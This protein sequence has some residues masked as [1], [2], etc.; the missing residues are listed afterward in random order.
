MTATATPPRREESQPVEPA[1]HQ[2]SRAGLLAGAVAAV[3]ALAAIGS[4]M[5]GPAAIV[6]SAPFLYVLVRKP[7]LRRLATR[8]ASRRPRET[9]LVIIG[10]LLGTAIITSSYVVGDTL[11]SSIRHR[12]FSQLGPVDELVASSGAHTG[13]AVRHALTRAQLTGVD[14]VLPMESLVASVSTDGADPRAEP[15]AQLLETNFA[16]A[17]RFGGDPGATGI[18]GS[19][20]RSGDAAIGDDLARELGVTPGQR[21]VVHAYGT[22]VPLRVTQ[23]LPRR[24]VAGLL[25]LD[26]NNDASPNVFVAPGTI[27]A[28]QSAAT[29]RAPG[30][31]PPVFLV[32]VSNT[33]TVAAGARTTDA[34]DA[35]L[36]RAVRALPAR[37]IPI[38]RTVLDAADRA[39]KSFTSFFQNFGY[40]SVLAGIL[41][42]VNI[43]V[44][45]AEERK[46]TLGMLRAVGLRRWSLI[47]SFSLEGWLYALGA[48]AAGAL[49]G[50]GIGRLVVVA[51]SKLFQQDH[52]STGRGLALH[53]AVTT[54]SI[55]AGF[56][57]GLVISLATV[58]GTSI[59]IS[60][61]NVIR[62]IRDLP[63]PPSHGG[64]VR[65]L[66]G[67]VLAV[68]GVLMTGGA[69]SGANTGLALL[70]PALLGFGVIVALGQL[71]PR[72]AIVSVISALILVWAVGAFSVVNGDPQFIDFVIQGV[73]LTGYAIALVTVNQESIGAALRTIGGGARNM[74]LRLGLAYP[75][76]KRFRT[77]LTLGMYAIVVFVLTLLVTISGL[78]GSQQSQF[79]AKLAGPATVEVESNQNAPIPSA[80]LAQLPGVRR[81]V[82]LSAN[83]AEFPRRASATGD[84]AASPVKVVG[85]GDS[86]IGHGA[87]Q[88]HDRPV[89]AHSD[90]AAYRQVLARPGTVVVGR[91]FS[92]GGGRGGPRNDRGVGIGQTIN[93]RDPVTGETHPL[94]VAALASEAGYGDFDHVYV[95][96]QTAREVFGARAT[97]NFALLT[98]SR[99]T[100]VDA[101]A[102]TIDGRFL[103]N[104]AD[105][106]SFRHL[107]RQ[108]FAQTQQF[109]ML[110][111][112]Y[113]ALGLLV[114]IAGLGVVMVRAVRE[115]RRQIGVLR[116]LG[117][118]RVAVRRAFVTESSFIALEGVIIGATLALV[119]CWR[120]V[121][122]GVIGSGLG[123]GVPW[124]QLT[125][126]LVGAIAA[127][128]LATASPAQQ[129]AGIAPA[130]A[131]RIAD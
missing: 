107:V 45:L 9:V 96:H 29:A 110:I 95:S 43:F 122:S 116:A 32:A 60:R 131:L 37:V 115:R 79:V 111:K 57:I 42:L 61:L 22:S 7:V 106:N 109:L 119:T 47:G 70:G 74:S 30:T 72:R 27:G 49:A 89:G 98:T 35:Q 67:A 78:F 100:D 11:R 114:G 124:F 68:V 86:F 2:R 23:V 55:R 8:N 118:S 15:R 101:L 120:L 81:V 92:P 75:L 39:G 25:T 127:S 73:V 28:L 46:T 99:G 63:E 113:V 33:G 123:F 31:A 21:I 87:P 117:F 80:A 17:A 112:G 34:V 1:T 125:L 12:A 10:A 94:V 93:L 19:T 69:L 108:A 76:A 24:G 3:A 77:G 129:A 6:L 88:L 104:G 14:G 103:A 102:T 26:A 36:E 58:L 51:A 48:A 52:T 83:T 84:A 16:D 62:A 54:H 121:S 126:W 130:V 41:L 5:V 56:T 90:A 97:G 44:M 65:R 20:P 18:T 4:G 128:L 53:F 71:L 66:L 82:S 85:F 13:D 40:F 50:I 91:D 38:K 59:Y 64:R 105:A